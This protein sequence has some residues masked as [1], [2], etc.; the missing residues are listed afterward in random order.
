MKGIYL[1]IIIAVLL[2]ID[3]TL[4]KI[5]EYRMNHVVAEN[6][7]TYN[8]VRNSSLVRFAVN[9]VK[10]YFYDLY[11]AIYKKDS[12]IVEKAM[13]KF[14]VLHAS[15]R[16]KS[17][18]Y[19]RAFYYFVSE[20]DKTRAGKALKLIKE[21]GDE[22]LTHD[23]LISYDVYICHGRKYLEELLE[24]LDKEQNDIMRAARAAMISQIYKNTGEKEKEEYYASL[25]ASS[26]Q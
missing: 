5:S 9:P 21:Q 26:L 10:L 7:E 2:G 1:V 11:R 23:A 13:R 22:K 6:E 20:N 16:Q 14:T 17:E 8:K 25:A 18:A 24:E 15:S 4:Q 3:I 19:A 12:V